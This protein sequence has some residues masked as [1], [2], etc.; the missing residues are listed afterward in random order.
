METELSMLLEEY[1]LKDK[2]IKIYL[3]LVINN[4]LTAYKIAKETH[5][6]RSTCYDILERLMQKGFVSKIE[7]KEKSIY[8]A[9][10]SSKILATIKNKEAILN[11]LMP[12]L[13]ILEQK[14]Q[15]NVK[16]LENPQAQHEFDVKLLNL[17]KQNKITFF[18]MI[19]S[20]PTPARP[21]QRLLIERLI[22]EA[23]QLKLHKKIDYK[24]LWDIKFKGDEFTKLFNVLG[25]NKFLKGILTKATTILF[26]NHVAF[27]YTTD[28]T[29]LIEIK[30]K[31]ISEEMKTYFEHMWKLARE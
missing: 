3:Y 5:I 15:T 28:T 16:F 30:N 9:N 1:G 29:G 24:G 22:K 2:E 14:Q 31:L 12:K 13:Q 21:G 27:L 8:S 4:Q 20:G 11:N 26:D 7:G 17:L 18:Y 19:G 10:E 25:E 23:K 6:H